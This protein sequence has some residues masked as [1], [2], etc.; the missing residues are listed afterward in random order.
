MI[1]YYSITV[2]VKDEMIL[3][4]PTMGSGSYSTP[5]HPNSPLAANMERQSVIQDTRDV[6]NQHYNK[7]KTY[8]YH[9]AL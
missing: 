2:D 5:Y 6:Y 8:N 7:G 9:L 1:Y 3:P 4:N